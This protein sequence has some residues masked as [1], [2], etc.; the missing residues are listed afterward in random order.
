MK[1]TQRQ[2][3]IW[4]RFS[5][6]QQKDGDSKTRQDRLNHALAKREGIQI[7]AEHFDEGVSVKDGATEK[8][9]K[10]ILCRSA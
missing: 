7:V 3:I 1:S 9:K 8:F 5:S 2:A 4:G 6:D 10:V